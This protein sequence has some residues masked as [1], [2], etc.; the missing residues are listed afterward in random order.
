MHRDYSSVDPSVLNKAVNSVANDLRDQEIKAQISD[1]REQG[2]DDEYIMAVMMVENE[3]YHS[4][5]AINKAT[6]S[7]MMVNQN[8]GLVPV[9]FKTY[10]L[11][12]RVFYPFYGNNKK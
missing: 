12:P 10:K 7:P 2:F 3:K 8:F 4:K 9:N 1:L 11:V 6:Q 5:S